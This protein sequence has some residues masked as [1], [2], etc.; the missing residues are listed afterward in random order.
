LIQDVHFRGGAIR[1]NP[2]PPQ[3]SLQ[4]GD[5]SLPFLGVKIVKDQLVELAA[6]R[7]IL[8]MAT[9]CDQQIEIA[10]EMHW[11]FVKIALAVFEPADHPLIDGFSTYQ[12]SA[13]GTRSDEE[14]ELVLGSVNAV[15]MPRFL[16]NQ[17]SPGGRKVVALGCL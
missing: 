1:G 2:Q 8:D 11:L 10:I 12:G 6:P 5:C 13:V 4:L 16:I 17:P 7:D 9:G 15:P 14:G 3:F